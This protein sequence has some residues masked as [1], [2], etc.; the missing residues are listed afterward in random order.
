M[1]H[2]KHIHSYDAFDAQE[3]C[4]TGVYWM[5][6]KMQEVRDASCTHAFP[7]SRVSIREA[8]FATMP[9]FRR[10]ICVHAHVLHAVV[11]DSS[12]TRTRSEGGFLW[13]AAS[14]KLEPAAPPQAGR[15]AAPVSAR[16]LPFKLL[17][18][19]TTLLSNP[20]MYKT[21]HKA[22]NDAGGGACNPQEDTDPQAPQQPVWPR[23]P[24]TV[25][26]TE[27]SQDLAVWRDRALAAESVSCKKQKQTTK[28]KQ[29]QPCFCGKALHAS[30]NSGAYA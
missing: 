11:Q 20:Y 24:D 22:S 9:A 7:Q 16:S 5:S 3:T 15:P 27:A 29:I 12:P 26:H 17:Q 10:L 1:I 6:D 30:C 28:K 25:A 14:S 4:S 8:R 2:R 13:A 23:S 18:P 19:H 21:Q